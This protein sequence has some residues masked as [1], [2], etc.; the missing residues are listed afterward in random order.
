MFTENEKI[1]LKK[2]LTQMK[3]GVI[4][5]SAMLNKTHE[6]IVYFG[7]NDDGIVTGCDVGKKII[8]KLTQEIRNYLKPFPPELKVDTSVIDEKNVLMLS[9][10]GDDTPYSAYGRFYIRVGDSDISMSSMELQHFFEDKVPNY[11][12]WEKKETVYDV[13]DIDEE[14]LIECVR[15]ANEKGRLDYVYKNA[16]DALNKFNLLTENGKLNNAGLYLF[17]N[18]KPVTIKEANYPT[19]TRTEFGEIKEFRGNIIQCIREAISYIQNHISYKASII[20]AQRVEVPEIPSRA[21]REIV[22]NS[23]AHC[24]YAIEGDY[25]QYIVFKSSVRIYN[26]GGISRNV[27]PVKF[28]SGDVGSKIR[29]VLIADVLYKFGYIDAFGTGF[30]RTFTLCANENID[31]KYKNDDFGFTFIFSRVPNILNDRINDRINSIDKE[32]IDL[33]AGNK[34]ISGA[35]LSEKLSKSPATIQRHL[36]LLSEKGLIRRIGSRKAG[37]WEIIKK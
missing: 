19:D 10:K 24:S 2:S 16:F 5:L 15:T 21:I 18:N 14:L 20:D 3:E 12:K 35:D 6:G 13:D 28:A 17:G 27:D 34:Y 22:V 29:N 9:A 25:N 11:S 7:I 4:S 1:E 37:Y 23:L 32:I 8:A 26:P 30:D 36:K 31:Y 33:I